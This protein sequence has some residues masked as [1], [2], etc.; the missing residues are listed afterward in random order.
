MAG[1]AAPFATGASALY[2]TNNVL[3][4]AGVD[5]IIARRTAQAASIVAGVG[6]SALSPLII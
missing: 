5:N 1:I 4:K 2:L 6:A 3:D